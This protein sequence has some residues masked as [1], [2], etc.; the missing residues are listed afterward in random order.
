MRMP[1]LLLLAVVLVGVLVAAAG[2]EKKPAPPPNPSQ[3][4]GT[5]ALDAATCR[6]KALA[7]EKAQDR[8]G[9]LAAWERVIDRCN[10]T[11]EQ[12]VEARARIKEL[13]PK[14]SRNTDP[15]KAHPWKVL[16]V[17]FRH[18]DFS[19]QDGEKTIEV[20]KTISPEDEKK[21]RKSV[22]SFGGHVFRH[23]SGMLRIDADFAVIDE[24][25]TKLYGDG[26]GP[27]C[28]APHLIRPFTDPLI[29]G[30]PYDTVFSY[31]KYNGDEGPDVPAPWI[32][33]TFASLGE[34]G[35]AGYVNVPWHTNYPLPGETD[36]EM[37]LHEWLHQ[38]DWMFCHVLHYPDELV[39][40]PDAGRFEGDDRPGGDP[41]YARKPT[42][43][44]WMRFY[45]H[46][47][48]DHITRQMWAEAAMPSR[49]PSPSRVDFRSRKPLP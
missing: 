23:S 27:F 41:E 10:A 12:R 18:L 13:R 37:E 39:P 49:R 47:M 21:I 5:Q 45:Q 29:K 28:P 3:A 14:V 31:V 17:I 26:K 15:R 22:E 38:I 2:A 34:M 24:P 6:D 36:G 40:T 1:G 33:S 20:R 42:E 19:W 44:T 25:L 9:A 8:P 32:A 30:K 11:E 46:I 4:L 35:G 43:S 16:V 7:A 48:E